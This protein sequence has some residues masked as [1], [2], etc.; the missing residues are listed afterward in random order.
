MELSSHQWNNVA[1]FFLPSPYKSMKNQN[2]RSQQNTINEANLNALVGGVLQDLGGAFSVP[3]VQIGESLGLY[4]ALSEKDPLSSPDLAAKTGLNERYLREWLSAQAASKYITFD[5][6]TEKFSMTPEQSFV[7]ANQGSP[8][9]LAPAF[10]AA[11]A[12][13][14]NMPQVKEAFRTGEGVAW[15][16]QTQCLSC[17]V[18]RF[19]RPGYDNHLVQSWLPALSGVV[20]KLQQ[21]G[22]VADVGCG[23]GIS[24]MLMARAFPKSNVHGFDF[25][26][27]SIQEATRHAKHHNLSNLEFHV[28]EASELPGKY[29]LI[30]MFDCLHDMGD[31]VGALKHLRAALKP[32]G[33]L[34]L[35]EP[36][37]GD[38]LQDNLNPIGRMYYSAST[39]VC[40]PTSL[41]QPTG[42]ALGAQ[43]GE[44]RLRKLLLDEAGFAVCRRATET[45]FNLILEARLEPAEE[46]QS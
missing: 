34:M 29:D 19:F 1:L 14:Q 28:R 16:E 46:R 11:A 24:T 8:F 40:V 20:E 37:A 36:M 44:K 2:Q 4:Q 9:Y 27:Q 31:P 23:H 35:V 5:P 10:G 7:F 30:T 18:A 41:A 38:R 17:A 13:Q 25:H 32:G 12:L 43:A 42:A 15:G 26:E 39:M 45:P 3:L 22:D 6:A 21:G 33:S